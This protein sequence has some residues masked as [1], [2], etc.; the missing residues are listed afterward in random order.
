MKSVFFKQS[1]NTANVHRIECELECA[2]LLSMQKLIGKIKSEI[3]IYCIPLKQILKQT[4]G[5]HGT[6]T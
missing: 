3:E 4:I 2:H 1:N 6:Q 5:F